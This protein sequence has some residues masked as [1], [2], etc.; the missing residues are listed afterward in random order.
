[1]GP[2]TEMANTLTITWGFDVAS[3][4]RTAVRSA[5]TSQRN[6]YGPGIFQC[7][8]NQTHSSVKPTTA[9][10][11]V[12]GVD[13][14]GC[15]WEA[16]HDGAACCTIYYCPATEEIA[17]EEPDGFKQSVAT[18]LTR[19]RVRPCSRMRKF[20]PVNEAQIESAPRACH[21]VVHRATDS[22]GCHWEA[23]NDRSSSNA[24]YYNPGTGEITRNK[25]AGF[26]IID[27]VV[28]RHFSSLSE[29]P[30]VELVG[31]MIPSEI[32][33]CGETD[34]S[35][36]IDSEADDDQLEGAATKSAELSAIFA[37]VARR[38][39][40]VQVAHLQLVDDSE[41]S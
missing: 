37:S 2:I 30:D 35:E 27:D 8:P 25:P 14:E 7:S 39:L 10:C 28:L 6:D 9:K 33:D 19:K 12:R 16:R 5:T 38:R 17:H 3:G 31:S 41:C 34:D 13:S 26:A 22:Q 24:F 1:M 4:R 11:V 18:T 20:S 36:Q 40:L 15:N 29:L 32:E 21:P 23:W